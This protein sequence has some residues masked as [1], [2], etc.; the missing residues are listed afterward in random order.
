MIFSSIH[1]K[2]PIKYPEAIEKALDF[3]RTHDVTQME[4]GRYEI[5]GKEIY[6]NVDE[7]QTESIEQRH[8]EEHEK[9]VDVQFLATGRERLGFVENHGKFEVL[10]KYA[11]RDLIFYKDVENESFVESRPGNFCIF[12]PGEIHRPLIASGKKMQIRKAIVKVAVS[13]L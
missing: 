6:V 3:L 13:L 11:D 4:P 1:T 5:Q 10:E 12:F 9:Y 2:Q 8:P 7:S